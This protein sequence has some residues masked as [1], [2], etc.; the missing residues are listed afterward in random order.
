MY[1]DDLGK[2]M[3]F[4]I[5]FS[6]VIAGSYLYALIRQM[7]NVRQQRGATEYMEEG[8]FKLQEKSDRFMYSHTNRVRIQTNNGSQGKPGGRRH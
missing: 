7:N 3:L 4:I 2:A 6:L 8:S 5:V 1:W